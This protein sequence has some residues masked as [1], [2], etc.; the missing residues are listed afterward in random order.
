MRRS[1]T[2][3]DDAARLTLKDRAARGYTLIELV[4]V[5]SIIGVLAAVALPSMRPAES[6]RLDQAGAWVAESVR[7][8]RAE[9]MRTGAPVHLEINK[10][11]DRVRVTVADLTGPSAA[12]G[13]DLLDPISKQPY[14]FVLSD[15]PGTGSVDITAQP[16]DYPSG[17]KMDAVVFDARGLPFIKSGGVFKRLTLGEI[18]IE[19]G[20]LERN[21]YLAPVTG[22][23]TRD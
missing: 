9:A 7:F 23:V 13:P 12:P 18:K 2:L 8:A 5:V 6:E 3:R 21:V 22:R 19:L 16:F 15:R 20:D 10:D 1:Y 17:G 14:D 11:T 4:T